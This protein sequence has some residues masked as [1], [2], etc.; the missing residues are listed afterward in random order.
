[1]KKAGCD[2]VERLRLLNGKSP[3]SYEDLK[4]LPCILILCE[5]GKMGDTFPKSLWY[6]DLR[7][8]YANSCS[9]R[10]PVE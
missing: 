10:A 9:V 3:E 7:M 5:K 1:M 8:R 2:W 4:D 6:Y